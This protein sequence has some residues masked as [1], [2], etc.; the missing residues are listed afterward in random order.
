MME[1]KTRRWVMIVGALTL[2][3]VAAV[4]YVLFRSWY[5]QSPVSW[6]SE[7]FSS[8]NWKSRAPTDRYK[9]YNDLAQKNVL[10]GKSYGDVVD[11]LGKPD[12]VAPDK[13][14]VTYVMKSGVGE[15]YSMNFVYLLHIGLN[16]KGV[17]EKYSVRAD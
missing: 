12:Y 2:I 11:L 1:I 17:V 5:Q 7:V 16:D 10:A 14:Y 6:P 4:A 3:I 8:E 15:S 9:L 13:R